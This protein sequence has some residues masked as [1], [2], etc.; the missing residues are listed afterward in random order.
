METS[1]YITELQESNN[2]SD[3]LIDKR[4]FRIIFK[5]KKYYIIY[6][7]NGRSIDFNISK[8]VIKNILVYGTFNKEDWEQEAKKYNYRY[9]DQVLENWKNKIQIK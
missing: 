3:L 6:I 7:Q 5:I 8:T 9:I 2:N 1:I 4:I